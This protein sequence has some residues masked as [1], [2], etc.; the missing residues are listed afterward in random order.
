MNPF[1]AVTVI[2]VGGA[3]LSAAAADVEPDA[4]DAAAP[5]SFS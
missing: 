4:D 3:T 1:S 2:S 5:G